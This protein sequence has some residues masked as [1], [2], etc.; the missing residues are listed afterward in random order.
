M[1]SKKAIA[2]CFCLL[3][4]TS[5]ILVEAF[6]F[7]KGGHN[8]GGSGLA[9]IL[10]AGLVTLLLKD[11]GRIGAR[12]GGYSLGHVYGHGLPVGRAGY[13]MRL[14]HS[15]HGLPL[16]RNA[17]GLVLDGI[18]QGIPL[19][20]LAHSLPLQALPHGI[21]VETLGHS[22]PLQAV[23]HGM[24]VEGFGHGIVLNNIGHGINNQGA[25]INSLRPYPSQ[26]TPEF[27]I[28]DSSE[29]SL[30]GA[31]ILDSDDLHQMNL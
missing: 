9:S 6:G 28:S 8:H 4:S 22:L 15:A 12:H 1:A 26:R 24:P 31:I 11:G 3:I 30:E 5:G 25:D 2:I 7:M 23:G 17:H 27:D 19:E 14:G 29:S 16:G 10:A 21:P 18:G 20:G 13:G